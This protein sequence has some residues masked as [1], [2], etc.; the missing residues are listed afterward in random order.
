MKVAVL[1][2]SGRAGSEI[3]KELASRGHSVT[4]IA[5]KPDAIPAASGVTPVAGD[6]SDPAALADLI[7][8]SDAVISALHFDVPAE[9]LLGALKTAGVPRLLVTGGAASLEVAPG[10]LLFDTPQFPAEWKPIAKGGLTF[11]DDLRLEKEIDWTFFSPAALIEEGP[12]TGAY[13]TGGDQLVVDDKGD[14]RISFADY[15]IAMVDELEQ[16]RHSRARFTAA[17]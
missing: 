7:K 2:A 5:R 12:R 14:S 9:T 4:A 16:H 15:A 1:G 6:A 17:Y 13:R 3:T 11:L 8:G 10:V